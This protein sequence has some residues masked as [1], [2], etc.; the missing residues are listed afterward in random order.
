MTGKIVMEDDAN[1]CVLPNLHFIATL[2]LSYGKMDGGV[3]KFTGSKDGN[4]LNYVHTSTTTN[5]LFSFTACH[6]FI[7]TF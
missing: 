6:M 7:S 2:L 1:L 5:T 3:K 4:V